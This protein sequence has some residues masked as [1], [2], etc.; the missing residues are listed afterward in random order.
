MLYLPITKA[1]IVSHSARRLYFVCALGAFSFFGGFIALRAAMG[2]SGVAA[3]DI[4][5]VAALL[6]RVLLFPAILGTAL[7]SVAMWYF[8]FAFDNSGWLLK[9]LWFLPLYL[10][11]PVGPV[12]Y[13]FFVYR[14]NSQVAESG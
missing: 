10:L 2:A 9:A 6:V 5:P 8:W 1:W 7:L 4:S 3:L 12:C 14:R 11:V 13:Y